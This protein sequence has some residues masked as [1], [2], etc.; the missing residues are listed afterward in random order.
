[1]GLDIVVVFFQGFAKVHF[2]PLCR[3]IVTIGT[4]SNVLSKKTQHIHMIQELQDL[5]SLQEDTAGRSQDNKPSEQS[6]NSQFSVSWSGR[7]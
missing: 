1:M 3:I 6:V 7:A 5:L 4:N 2:S